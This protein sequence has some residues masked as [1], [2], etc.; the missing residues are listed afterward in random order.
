MA[1]RNG[2]RLPPEHQTHPGQYEGGHGSQPQQ[3][4]AKPTNDRGAGYSQH[5]NNRLQNELK[6]RERLAA[7][8]DEESAQW[9]LENRGMIQMM[10]V[11]NDAYQERNRQPYQDRPD[12]PSGS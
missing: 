9:L 12:N 7:A 1:K 2:N 3:T 4:R 8:G 5:E 11:L 10:D 6:R